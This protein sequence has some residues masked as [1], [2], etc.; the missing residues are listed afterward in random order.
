MATETKP[1]DYRRL[2]RKVEQVVDELELGDEV[3]AV[4]HAGAENVIGKFRAELGIYGGRLYKRRGDFYVLQATFGEAKPVPAG[5]EVPASYPPIEVCLEERVVYMEAGDPRIDA[6]LEERLGVHEFAAV[7]VGNAEYILAFNIAPGFNHDDILL[8]L[9]IL[10]HSLNQ[11]IRQE[12]MQ[13][14]FREARKIQASILP[15]RAPDFGR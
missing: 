4:I 6:E 3:D 1:L 5:L 13:E 12:R 9:S 15:R 11:K 14:V 2:M 7:E 8:S 10:R